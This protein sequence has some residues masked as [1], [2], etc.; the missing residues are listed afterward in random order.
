V[1]RYTPMNELQLR[2]CKAVDGMKYKVIHLT[3]IK[4]HTAPKRP[5]PSLGKKVRKSF[6]NNAPGRV[7][8]NLPKSL[9]IQNDSSFILHALQFDPD[10]VKMVQEEESRGY[11]VL[12][13]MP[14][15]G[16]PLFLGEDTIE[17]LGSK[18]GKR[19]LRGLDKNKTLDKI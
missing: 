4:L 6:Q 12:I 19:F 3:D 15:G 10:F 9:E 13:S 5:T 2:P 11:K 16:I 7:Y 18:N 1:P 8:D 17:F 14:K